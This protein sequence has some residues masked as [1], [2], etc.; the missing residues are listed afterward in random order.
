MALGRLSISQKWD[1]GWVGFINDMGSVKMTSLT[2]VFGKT[3]ST[4]TD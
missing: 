1:G 3:V 4:V 2:T